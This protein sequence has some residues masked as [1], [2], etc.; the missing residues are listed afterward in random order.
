[1]RQRRG[2]A[3][4]NKSSHC[5]GRTYTVG[6]HPRV[7]VFLGGIRHSP[8]CL[9]ATIQRASNERARHGCTCPDYKGCNTY[10]KRENARAPFSKGPKRQTRTDNTKTEQWL[11]Y[12]RTNTPCPL[13]HS[14]SKKNAM[15]S[16][17]KPV[18]FTTIVTTVVPSVTLSVKVRTVF[19]T[20]IKSHT[21]LIFSHRVVPG[22]KLRYWY[23]TLPSPHTLLHKEKGSTLGNN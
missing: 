12:I 7:R 3:M 8:P 14:N 17:A 4:Q 9:E 21:V 5:Y 18:G 2:V 19:D 22:M 1:M 20:D 13:M 10:T 6:I 16:T 23:P 11:D 15:F